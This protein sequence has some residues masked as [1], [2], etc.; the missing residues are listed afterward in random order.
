M[1]SLL[2]I[3]NPHS[4]AGRIVQ[5][6]PALLDYYTARGWLV[7]AYPTQC[8][9]DCTRMVQEHAAEFDL[10]VICGGDGMLHEMVRGLLHQEKRPVMGYIPLGTTNDFA[11]THQ[12]SRVP[13]EAAATTLYGTDVLM[14]TGLFN[15]EAFVY[16]AAF[17]VATSVS[18][19]TSQ[20]EKKRWGYLAYVI[21][22][23]QSV[24]FAH[25]ENNACRMKVKW[26]QGE[27]EGDFIFGSI[28]NSRF[29]AGMNNFIDERFSCND[30]L[31]EGFFIRRPMNLMELDQIFRGIREKNYTS[32]FFV[33]IQSPWFELESEPVVWTLD[34]EYGGE[35]SQAR[36][37]TVR[38]NLSMRLPAVDTQD[39]QQ[40]AD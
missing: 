40:Q 17:G 5:D 26:D 32:D 29:I 3:Y 10:C 11:S 25:W 1:N 22:G 39:S 19:A 20:E 6:L 9:G 34:G 37:E 7:S 18:W 14:D 13:L 27:V 30:G 36:I 21:R 35:H 12:L 38:E 8:A 31:L 23:L 2:L 4:G 33:Q 15:E 16:V 24:D 28:S